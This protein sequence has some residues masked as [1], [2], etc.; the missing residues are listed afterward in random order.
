MAIASNH[1]S[2]VF[3]FE[4]RHDSIGRLCTLYP[5]S[6]FSMMRLK[7]IISLFLFLPLSSGDASYIPIDVK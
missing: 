1:S 3:A 6:T 7:C 5:S 4:L 2:V